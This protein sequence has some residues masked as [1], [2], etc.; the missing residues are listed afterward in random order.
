MRG[1]PHWTTH[2]HFCLTQVVKTGIIEKSSSISSDTIFQES[3]YKL[4][5]VN[6]NSS[7]REVILKL[8]SQSHE[9]TLGY[10][11]GSQ[12]SVI[13]MLHTVHGPSYICEIAIN[14]VAQSPSVSR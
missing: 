1:S 2:F 8:Q 14:L 12:I 7:F 5:E 4:L 9:L 13:N 10:N 6:E 3:S 11:L